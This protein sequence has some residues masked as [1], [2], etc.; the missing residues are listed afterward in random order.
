MT[1]S[2]QPSPVPHAEDTLWNTP[3]GKTPKRGAPSG[4]AGPRWLETVPW[5]DFARIAGRKRLRAGTDLERGSL[6]PRSSLGTRCGVSGSRNGVRG[7]VLCVMG[8]WLYYDRRLSGQPPFWPVTA[9]IKSWQPGIA[10][11]QACALHSVNVFEGGEVLHTLMS[12]CAAN[13]CCKLVLDPV[14]FGAFPGN[15]W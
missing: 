5:A 3:A 2:G 8:C 13:P 15:L 1:V 14:C 10:L 4:G 11:S 9:R 12:I 6:I 7:A